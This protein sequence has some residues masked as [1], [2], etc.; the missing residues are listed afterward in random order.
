MLEPFQSRREKP[1]GHEIIYTPDT[2][3][4]V[5]KVIFVKAG[6]KLSLQYHTEKEETMT[7]FSGEALLWYQEKGQELQK[8]PMQPLQGYTIYPGVLHRLEALED[9]VVLEV[10]APESGTTVRVQD[11]YARSDEVFA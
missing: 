2:L 11:D 1:W 5:G 4:R 8:I 10:S 3:S 9:S 7:L 6:C